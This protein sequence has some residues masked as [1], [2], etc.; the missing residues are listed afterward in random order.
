MAPVR[1]FRR[2]PFTATRLRQAM[3][4]ADPGRPAH[5]YLGHPSHTGADLRS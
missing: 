2:L 1:R 4:V 5:M 3:L